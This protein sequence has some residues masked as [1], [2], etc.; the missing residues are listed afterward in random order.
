[1]YFSGDVHLPGKGGSEHNAQHGVVLPE[2][3]AALFVSHTF[4]S[5]RGG[6]RDR[7]SREDLLVDGSELS[8]DESTCAISCRLLR[9]GR[10]GTLTIVKVFQADRLLSRAN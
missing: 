3:E 8:L 4:R 9:S 2:E 10:K 1:M 5:I 7:Y 6:I